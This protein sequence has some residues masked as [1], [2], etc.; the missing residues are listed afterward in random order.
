MQPRQPRPLEVLLAPALLL[1]VGKQV[2]V[3]LVDAVRGK[4]CRFSIR[5]QLH[6]QAAF[7]VH[8]DHPIALPPP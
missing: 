1:V 2:A 8:Q 3:T 5:E 6:H 7:Q 4:C